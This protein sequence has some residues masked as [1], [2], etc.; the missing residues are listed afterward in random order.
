MLA[1]PSSRV[2]ILFLLTP[3]QVVLAKRQVAEALARDLED[4]VRERGLHRRTAVVAHADEPVRRRKE[5]NVD[6]ERIFVDAR[7][8]ELVEVVL[9]DR[10]VLDVA[11]LVHRVVVEPRDLAFDLLLDRQRVHQAEARLVRDVDALELDAPVS[12][13]RSSRAIE[14][15]VPR[16]N[17]IPQPDISAAMS[18]ALIMSALNGSSV[19]S[20]SSRR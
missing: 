16:G 15:T 8:R 7:H 11:G 5:L 17:G 12:T 14:R 9:G 13:P 18:S 2:R 20:M 3:S 19:R 6:R 1:N 4:G 10:A